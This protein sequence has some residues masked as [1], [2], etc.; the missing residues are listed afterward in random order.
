MRRRYGFTQ[1]ELD[2]HRTAAV[3]AATLHAVRFGP[4]EAGLGG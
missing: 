1:D 4:C 2:T 3:D